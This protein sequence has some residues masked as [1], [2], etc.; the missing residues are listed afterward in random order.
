LRARGARA[1]LANEISADSLDG[2]NSTN[3][4]VLV[5]SAMEDTHIDVLKSLYSDPE[6]LV[7]AVGG[8]ALFRRMEQLLG[9]NSRNMSVEA[10][11]LHVN[12]LSVI[13]KE[14]EKY[15][16]CATLLFPHLLLT[17]AGYKRSTVVWTA[18]LQPTMVTKD[19]AF[20]RG[21]SKILVGV[22][23]KEMRGDQVAMAK[24]NERVVDMMSSQSTCCS[25]AVFQT[26]S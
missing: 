1:L 23:W 15:D 24:F 19:A 6:A 3:I 21:C 25:R 8:A 16:L 7:A 22:D 20:L 14:G 10:L 2:D 18:L 17:K 9:K 5:L 26:I 4:G 13:P 11:S 12:F